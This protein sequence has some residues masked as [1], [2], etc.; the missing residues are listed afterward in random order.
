MDKNLL[1]IL[2]GRVGR[3]QKDLNFEVLLSPSD[4]RSLSSKS[5]SANFILSVE[6]LD[7]GDLRPETLHWSSAGMLVVVLNVVVGLEGSILCAASSALM[8]LGSSVTLP[9]P[10][11]ALACSKKR[12]CTT[13]LSG[14]NSFCAACMQASTDSFLQSRVLHSRFLSLLFRS[15]CA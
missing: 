15:G 10:M 11:A 9:L 5:S 4:C 3:A 13:T 1:N 7:F 14:S 2:F 6:T 8:L 12:T